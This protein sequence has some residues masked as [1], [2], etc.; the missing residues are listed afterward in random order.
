MKKYFY[1]LVIAMI[2]GMLNAPA[3]SAQNY[4][5]GTAVT[6]WSGEGTAAS[7]YLI[8]TA[9]ELAGLAKRTN[10]E[11]TFEGKYFKLMADLWLSNPADA[12]DDRPL[13]DPIGSSNIMNGDSEE[14]PGGFYGKDYYFKGNFDGNGHIIYNL[15]YAHD[16][17]FE[18]NFNDPFNDGTYDFTGWSKALFGN[19]ENATVTNLK[20][21]GVSIQSQLRG[22]G[23]A[24][25][26]TN[27]TITD[28]TVDGYILCGT[29]E[30]MGGSAAGIVTEAKG[31]TFERCSSSAGVRSI[32]GAGGISAYAY[33][34]V[35]RNCNASGSVAAMRT[36]GGIAGFLG[37]KSDVSECYTSAE[38]IQLV[39]K[40]QG[41]D[42]GGFA[43]VIDDSAVRLCSSTGN[44]TVDANGYGFAGSIQNYAVV[45]SCWAKCD[46]TKDGYAV[47]MAS[48]V[49]EIGTNYVGDGPI[50]AYV[51]NCYGVASYHY[52]P[53]PSDVITT[54]NHLGGFTTGIYEKSQ[55]VNCFYNCDTA[56][57]LNLIQEAGE[58]PRGLEFEFGLTTAYMQSQA[59]VDQLN[60]MAGIMG[61]S[62][63]KYN[64]GDYP[65]PTG[66]TATVSNAP[67]SGGEG[68]EA[69]PW[70]VST[71]DDLYNVA[72]ITNHGWDFSGQY[73]RQNADIALN[74]PFEQWGEEMPTPWTPIGETIRDNRAFLFKGTYDGALHTVS[75]MYIDDSVVINA[76]LFGV[77]GDGAVIKNLGVTDAYVDITESSVTAG[78][79]VGSAAFWSDNSDGERRISNCWTS[80]HI[81]STTASA[82]IGGGSQWGKTIIDN[83]YTT[84]EIYAKTQGGAFFGTQVIGDMPI[85]LTSSYFNGS[86]I[87]D[88]KGRIPG[89]F[90]ECITENCYFNFESIEKYIGEIG[91]YE[92]YDY[93]RTSAYMMTPEF[94]NELSYSSAAA[95]LESP[96]KYTEGSTAS[97]FGKAPEIDVT[98][99]IDDTK[100]VTY[101]AIAGS[102]ISAPVVAAPEDDL[103]LQGWYNAANGALFNFSDTQVNAP[104]TLEAKWGKGLIPDYTPFKNK[105]SK[106][107][108]IK[109]PEQLL[110][111]SNIV[112]GKVDLAKDGVSQTDYEGYTIQLGN[113]IE[114]NSIE[115]YNDWG[116][117]VTPISFPS[118]GTSQYNFKGVFDGQNY[119]ITGLYINDSLWS[120]CFGFFT[121]IDKDA[122][123]KNLILK[124]AFIEAGFTYTEPN[125]GLLTGHLYGQ[126]YRC[127]AEG[128]II[129]KPGAS[130]KGYV[131]GLIGTSERN[132]ICDLHEC[133]AIVDAQLKNQ[134][135]GG[136]I[137][138]TGANIYDSFARSNVKWE[139]YGYFGGLVCTEMYNTYAEN[140]WCESTVDW[141]W[142]KAKEEEPGGAAYG[143]NYKNNTGV[144][145]DKTVLGEI[146]GPASEWPEGRNPYTYGTGLSTTDMK[147]MD[148]T[149]GFN[150]TDIWGRRNDMND[151]YPYLRWTAPGLE[152]DPEESVPVESISLDINEFTGV[153][154]KTLQLTATLKPENPSNTG[155][156]WSTSDEAVA[157]VSETGLVTLIGAG[158][159]VITASADDNAEIKATCDVTVVIPVNG[160]SISTQYQ[161]GYVGD[162]YQLE[163]TLTPDNATNKNILWSSTDEQV[164]T[165]DE[166]GLVL[167]VGAGT[168]T[169]K[170][171]SESNP[172]INTF[173][174]FK[175][176]PAVWVTEITL[177]RESVRAKMGTTMSLYATVIPSNATNRKLIWSS[178]DERVVTVDE[179]GNISLIGVGE[180]IVTATS[181]QKPEISASC[182]VTVVEDDIPITGVSLDRTTYTGKEGTTVQLTATVLPE[183]TTEE[184]RLS[185]SA[186]PRRV[187]TVDDNGLVTL[188]SEGTATVTVRCGSFRAEC[189]IIVTGDVVFVQSIKFEEENFTLNEGETAVLHAMVLPDNATNPKLEWSTSNPDIAEVY[190]GEVFAKSEGTAEITV[191]STDGSDVSATC[192]VTV[193]GGSG[194][195]DIKIDPN[196]EVVIL[197]LQG[198]VV[199]KGRYVDARLTSGVYIVR[200]ANGTIIKVMIK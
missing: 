102:M 178:S 129:I 73:I 173:C 135:F 29:S 149:V 137:Y 115:E 143:S 45:E 47:W 6:E 196:A 187:A 91:S 63:W 28:I 84:A 170:A 62:L 55:A 42:I 111:F 167:F 26:A 51:R 141:K 110:G 188:V 185:W 53:V 179:T 184:Y 122:V 142:T 114:W 24:C 57:G 117:G 140:S 106:T 180:A 127:G 65:T 151:G 128:K 120:G 125:I 197:S 1:T 68:S 52:Q 156:N 131:G 164:V 145:Y 150:Y 153:P 7:P 2:T 158:K 96:W 100:S 175:V 50:P 16:S 40:R 79:L 193:I 83:C 38:I 119:T 32:H 108:T 89:I 160:I 18:D 199:F 121:A 183:N 25:R 191:R 41:A 104:V 166:N 95:G 81:E 161:T 44:L 21:S 61:T 195:N 176:D 13:W 58:D 124:N 23:L 34:S 54:G 174:N 39:A 5:D 12:D 90:N 43:G 186:S 49:G 15:W 56:T 75:N 118:I 190:D 64:P 93:G 159:A 134:G 171:V 182:A 189:E 155:I 130:K 157:T 74:L 133:Y 163:A 48:F 113:D 11:E 88:G 192:K 86:F 92:Y 20:L 107:Y 36:A 31:C 30:T 27:S 147:R 139:D 105:F 98:Y 126:V 152:N 4:W 112:N 101:K 8:T 123:V 87:P 66:V 35:F 71:K 194:I 19:L 103:T 200:L 76:G 59:F 33:S 3:A 80:G 181:V 162:K 154:G 46:I 97:F 10:N 165:V 69:N 198:H 9:Q 78:I 172:E 132:E 14:N 67:F 22:A 144:Y 146:F 148:A 109:T 77:I 94:V 168:A 85:Y 116:N 70:I 72:R 169:V 82:F 177:N 37:E 60:E 136:L 138:A 99:I 17:E